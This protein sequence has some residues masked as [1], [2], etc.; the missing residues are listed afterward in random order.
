MT[1]PP[2]PLSLRVGF[3][4]DRESFQA[5]LASAFAI[6]QSRM[7]SQSLSAIVEVGRLVTSGEL[8]VDGAMHL[9]VDGRQKVA[10]TNAAAIDPPRGAQLSLP[11]LEEVNP[12]SAD[13]LSLSESTPST[14][15]TGVLWA[16][17][18]SD[19]AL[20]DM[21]EQRHVTEASAAAIALR[22]AEELVRRG[23]V[24]T[25]APPIDEPLP[26]AVNSMDVD[27]AAF[28][29]CIPPTT[30]SQ[31]R[32]RNLWARM[33]VILAIALILLLSWM[34]GR[35]IWLAIA[36]P[37][38]P[39]PLTATPD[40]VPAQPE[41]AGQADPNPPPLVRQQSRRHEISPDSLLVYD[42][43]RV[44]FR[45][46]S[47]QRHGELSAPDPALDPRREESAR[48]LQRVEPEYPEAAKQQHIQGLV[49]LEADVGKD[50]AVEQLAVISG[51]SILA[52][53][54]SGA[55]FKWRFE[56]LVQNG[57]AVPFQTRVKV[58]FVLPR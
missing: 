51:N 56:P 46:K 37:Q 43:G 39:P 16:D 50:G 1:K 40:A 54:A 28:P 25:S 34:L 48:L 5:V 53:A 21:V 19:L 27:F 15:D 38:G 10:N 29:V 7:D 31:F 49:V 35:V 36:K 58:N 12:C 47:P 20:N 55:V 26:S 33:L 2:V 8:D 41:E 9:I 57:R 13:L 17:T 22:R 24:G 4:V 44:V 14:Y 52:A 23:G 30:T 6:Q 45:L 18:A 32:L 3:T 42:H 11:G